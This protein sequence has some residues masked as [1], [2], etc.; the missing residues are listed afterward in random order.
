M[1]AVEE[2]PRVDR[3]RLKLIEGQAGGLFIAYVKAATG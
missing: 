2:L 1:D 3:K